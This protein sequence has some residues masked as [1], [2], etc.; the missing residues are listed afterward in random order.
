MNDPTTVTKKYRIPVS[1][2]EHGYIHRCTDGVE[3]EQIYKELMY[4]NE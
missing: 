2:L 3:L 4:K 1:H